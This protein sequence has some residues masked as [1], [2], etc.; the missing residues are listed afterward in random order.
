[1]YGEQAR[2]FDDELH[3]TIKHSKKG[4]VAMAGMSSGLTQAGL[5]EALRYRVSAPA[6]KVAWEII[7]RLLTGCII[8]A[9]AGENMNASQF[10]FTLGPDLDSLDEKHTIFGEVHIPKS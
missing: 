8:A 3:P 9:G 6:Q 4:L 10:Y 1:M 5:R 7:F 2:F